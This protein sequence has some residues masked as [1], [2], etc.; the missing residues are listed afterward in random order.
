MKFIVKDCDPNTG[1]ADEDGY[2]D[3]Y[4][5]EGVE[6]LTADYMTA[7]YVPNF[8]NAWE[9]LGDEAE[10]IETY[11][12]TAVAGVKGEFVS[13][14]S[15]LRDV[16]LGLTFPT[17]PCSSAAVTNIIS[18]LGMQICDD[19]ASVKDRATTH[20]LLLSGTFVGGVPV[21]VRCRMAADTTGVTL[22]VGVRSNSMAVS[23]LIANAVA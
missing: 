17:F 5:L 1:E 8:A 16:E 13:M 4:Q 14:S 12:L 18:L 2:D 21:L 6:L 7:T 22:E 9:E 11:S 10:V 3:E 23:E 15:N 19:S 20:T